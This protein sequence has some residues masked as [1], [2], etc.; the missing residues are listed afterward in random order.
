LLSGR[1]KKEE[2]GRGEG[3]APDIDRNE[4]MRRPLPYKGGGKKKPEI[5]AAYKMG[6][7]EEKLR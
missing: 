3:F 7:R 4:L 5:S 6:G 2:K 1:K